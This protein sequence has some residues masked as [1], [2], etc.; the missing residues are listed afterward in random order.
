M[1]TVIIAQEGPLAITEERGDGRTYVLTSGLQGPPGPDGSPGD[2]LTDGDKG[3]VTV[4]AAGTVWTVDNDAITYPKMQNVSAASKLLGRGDDAAGDVEEITLGAGLTMTGNT[5]DASGGATEAT[6]GEVNTGTET[7]K[8]VSPD[9]LAGSNFG[10]AVVSILVTD[11]NGDDLATGDGQAHFFVPSTLNGRNLVGAFAAV[12]TV[13]SS[14]LPTVQ[15]HNLTQAAD[16]LTT[17]ITID[18]SEKHSKDATTPA[19]IDAANDD[20]ATGDELR[21]D[22]DVAG[23]GAKGL[24]VELHFRL[25]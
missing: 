17:P 12:T 11:P 22:V 8:Y 7:A 20:V 2:G 10:T 13:S 5:L 19:V 18:A 6:A 16:M 14:G 25:A 9:S 24:V 1:T 15:I 23:T 21:I 4:S 3:D